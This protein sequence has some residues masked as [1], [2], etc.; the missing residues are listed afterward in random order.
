MVGPNGDL[1]LIH[2]APGTEF[3]STI[4]CRCNFIV[5]PVTNQP[6]T[7]QCYLWLPFDTDTQDHS[8]MKFVTDIVG[9]AS[10]D[11]STSA[12]NGGG[13]FNTNNDGWLEVPGLKT[14]DL[15]HAASWCL[16]FKCSGGVCSTDGGLLSN[17]KDAAQSSFSI[18]MAS[19][20]GNSV[21]YTVS[22]S[23]PTGSIPPVTAAVVNTINP[24]GF[25]QMCVVYDGTTTR[26]WINNNLV[27]A[28]VSTGNVNIA[29]CP[30]VVGQ[31]QSFGQFSGQLDDV[32]VCRHALS[33]AEI[34]AHFNGDRAF[35]V[36]AGDIPA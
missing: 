4:T 14:I 34:N 13:C 21:T 29:H 20:A 9:T 2:C 24:N 5:E 32:L 15:D 25:N 7:N 35:L 12:T 30:Y 31:D 10:L 16:F 6:S 19:R 33:A 17:N 8:I 36:N 1:T 18:I 11:L 27:D 22:F 3:D 28:E 23:H 26:L